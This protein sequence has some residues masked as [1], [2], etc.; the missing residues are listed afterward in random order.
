[1]Q[2]INLLGMHADYANLRPF[3]KALFDALGITDSEERE[4]GNYVDGYYLKGSRDGMVF[5]IALSDEETYGDLPYWIHV[6]E[7]VAEPA[8]LE[9]TVEQL[10]RAKALPAGFRFAHIVNF[11]KR[12]EQRIDY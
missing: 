1:M 7:D 3:A 5:A 8:A 6:S 2:H 4:S 9:A 10:I 11:G 12:G